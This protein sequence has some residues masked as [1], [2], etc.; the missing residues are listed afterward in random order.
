MS[1]EVFGVHFM[2]FNGGSPLPLPSLD[3]DHPGEL[4]RLT[5]HVALSF[6]VLAAIRAGKQP[7]LSDGPLPTIPVNMKFDPRNPFGTWR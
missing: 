3:R 1:I 2:G 5:E 4:T 6:A 7:S